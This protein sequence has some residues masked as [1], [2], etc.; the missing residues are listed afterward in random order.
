MK[1]PTIDYAILAFTKDELAALVAAVNKTDHSVADVN[2]PL[3]LA[4]KRLTGN[5]GCLLDG[6][7]AQLPPAVYE[8]VYA[9]RKAVDY[10]GTTDTTELAKMLKP[11]ADTP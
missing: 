1:H 2:G 3:G 7:P 11:F 9:A 4:M 8:L 10:G 5:H 6:R